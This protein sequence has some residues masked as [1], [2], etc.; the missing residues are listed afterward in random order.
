MRIEPEREV[1]DVEIA[2]DE[3]A[4]AFK[5]IDMLSATFEPDAYE[6]EYRKVMTE[7]ITA[8]IEGRQ[9]VEAKTPAPAKAVDLLAALKASI[10]AAETRSPSGDDAP[11]TPAKPKQSAKKVSAKKRTSASSR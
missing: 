6:D 1:A 2:D 5:F 8:K 3:L 4:I 9:T 10:E 11:S 7:P